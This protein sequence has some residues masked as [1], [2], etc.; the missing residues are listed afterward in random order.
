MR[1]RKGQTAM[2]YLMTYGWAII[3]VIIVGVVL[4][5]LNV[6]TPSAGKTSSG[7][8]TFN[9]G[10]NFRIGSDG[11]ATII[12]VNADKQG[13]T[14]SMN[15]LSIANSG[16]CAGA[17]GSK[18]SGENWTVTCTGVTA[19]AKGRPYTG[20]AVDINY[21]VEGLTLTESGTLT[22]KYD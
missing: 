18:N 14:I 1:S 15:S 2:E 21:T 19:G 4:W 5:R 11:S 8:D 10:T 13:R 20:V 16:T 9:V 7:F 6:F 17:S 22:G 3:I 12:L